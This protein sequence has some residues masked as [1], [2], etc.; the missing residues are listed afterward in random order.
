MKLEPKT[1]I[2]KDSP[3]VFRNQPPKTWEFAMGDAPLPANLEVAWENLLDQELLF[4]KGNFQAMFDDPRCFP[5]QRK[6]EM[7]KMLELAV[8]SEAKVIMEIG[9]DKGGGVLGWCSY[10]RPYLEVMLCCEIRGVPY[11]APFK[12][13][14][15]EVEF[16]GYEASSYDPTTVEKVKSD[17]AGRKINVLFI[18]G[19]K[20][21]F[22]T[23]FKLYRPL[24]ANDGLVFFHDINE[25]G[26]MREAYE[27]AQREEGCL[28]C[29]IVDT[30]SSLL[31]LQRQLRKFSCSSAHEQWL[32]QWA[33]RSCGVGILWL[34]TKKES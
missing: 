2:C 34:G 25:P 4:Y 20:S 3:S 9:T 1:T 12:K 31:A 17:L 6:E 8:F 19:D 14:F 18:D 32:R 7:Q 28:C 15:P 10:V 23:D 26:K 29:E 22:L 27:I 24:V 21:H 30:S 11:L 33:G 13:R 16:H 5:L